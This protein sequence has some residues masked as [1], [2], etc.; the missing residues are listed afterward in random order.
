MRSTRADLLT[1]LPSIYGIPIKYLALLFLVV[2]NSGLVLIMR[3]SRLTSGPRYLTSTA[4]VL[5]E[6]LKAL[7]CICAYIREQDSK[8]SYTQLPTIETSESPNGFSLRQMAEDVFGPKSGYL[9]MM[10]PAALYT[11]Q[12]NLQFVAASNLD[13]ATF[14]VTYQGKILTTAFFAVFM[15]RQS[16]SPRKWV[17]LVVLTAGV[18]MV[19]L[20]S[21]SST[22]SK[23]TEGNWVTGMMAVGIAC[24]LS[25][26]AGVYFEKILKGESVS[27]WVRNVQLSSTSIVIAATG[28]LVWDGEAIKQ[29]GFFQGYN[30]LVLATILV[31]AVGGIIVALVVKYADNILKGFATSIAIILSIVASVFMFDFVVTGSFMAGAAIVLLATYLYALPDGPKK[32]PEPTLLE[33]EEADEKLLDLRDSGT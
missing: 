12:N 3:S 14:Q 21:A 4:V 22:P 30:T 26:L 31:Q 29:S 9:K 24:V 11:L 17:S 2:Q 25:G 23:K 10:I 19:Q 16:L 32:A 6:A 15:L 13:A 20:Q 28:A 5:S 33:T 18:A 27:I 7:V 8:S 1:E